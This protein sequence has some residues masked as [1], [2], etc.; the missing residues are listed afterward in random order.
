[1]SLEAAKNQE[2]LDAHPLVTR[3][4]QT[5]NL[6]LFAKWYDAMQESLDFA[7]RQLGL[8]E[9]LADKAAD[10]QSDRD[11]TFDAKRRRVEE[12]TANAGAEIKT[13]F[14]AR[15]SKLRDSL[16]R[17]EE[18][19]RQLPNSDPAASAVAEIGRQFRLHAMV[20]ELRSVP[21]HERV[22]I[23]QQAAAAGDPLPFIACKMPFKPL[24]EEHAYQRMADEMNQKL[25][26]ETVS[27][28]AA[29]REVLDA[30]IVL[31]AR[32]ESRAA[33]IVAS[34]RKKPNTPVEVARLEQRLGEWPNGQSAA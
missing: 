33:Q 21:H 10:I 20:D 24:V 25:R 23:L 22:G 7:A 12:I 5:F 26:P 15:T 27:R 30:E 17:A 31:G 34:P 14:E 11:L 32:T 19:L 1:M 18:E 6:A 29:L 16:L 4:G 28:A 2:K 8:A 9:S 3:F 13:Y